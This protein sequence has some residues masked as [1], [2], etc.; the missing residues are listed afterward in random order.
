M[1]AALKQESYFKILPF[2]QSACI[3]FY[4]SD[5]GIFTGFCPNVGKVSKNPKLVDRSTQKQVKKMIK[6]SK[7]I[8]FFK[9][10]MCRFFTSNMASRYKYTK[11]NEGEKAILSS[12]SRLSAMYD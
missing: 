1:C 2:V 3:K 7:I 4:Y 11:R 8:L 6:T 5:T 12:I 10:S 9:I